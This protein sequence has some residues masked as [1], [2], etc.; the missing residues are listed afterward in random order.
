MKLNKIALALIIILIISAGV[1]YRLS[2]QRKQPIQVG[3]SGNVTITVSQGL[4]KLTSSAFSDNQD[5]PKI[6]TCDGKNINPPLSLAGIPPGTVSLAL[7]VNDPDA[8]NGNWVHWTVWN[9][10]PSTKEIAE[11]QT[12]DEAV[13]GKTNFGKPG[14]GGPC[15]PSGTH[16]Y[17]FTLYALNSSLNIGPEADEEELMK[18]IEGHAV[19]KTVLTGLYGR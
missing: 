16:H 4:M 13:E 10:N 12:P 7:T 11:G 9:I 1:Y 18:V 2:A 8:P 6:Y 5:I 17:I 14:Y 15:P 19:G 3:K